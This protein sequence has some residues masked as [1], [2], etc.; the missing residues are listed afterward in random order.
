MTRPSLGQLNNP[1]SAHDLLALTINY[2]GP[3]NEPLPDKKE[4]IYWNNL[5]GEE[6]AYGGAI[7]LGFQSPE[8]HEVVSAKI[9][10]ER[11]NNL[12]KQL[13]RIVHK[14]YRSSHFLRPAP[15]Y[16]YSPILFLSTDSDLLLL[17]FYS[18]LLSFL[19]SYNPK[20][21]GKVEFFSFHYPTPSP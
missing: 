4:V 14:Y 2:F 8:Y 6:N 3:N 5:T 17:H 18:F 10:I 12:Y 16:I 20:I 9:L 1:D 15:L 7:A 19:P 11:A 21:L 13:L